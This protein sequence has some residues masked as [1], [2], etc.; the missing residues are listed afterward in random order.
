M[1]S[2]IFLKWMLPLILVAGLVLCS[3]TQL[4]AAN[5]SP[6][7]PNAWNSLSPIQ[8]QALAP[9]AKDW[10]SLPADR[11]QKWLAIAAKY[12]HMSPEDQK[13]AQEK[14]D[15]YVK[16]T[17]EQRR[18]VRENY[19]R[20][21]KYEPEQ[22]KQKWDEYNQ[23]PEDERTQLANHPEKKK[24]ITNLPTPAESKEQKLQPLKT[25]KKPAGSPITAPTSASQPAA[26]SAPTLPANSSPA[27]A[28]N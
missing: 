26:R 14:M 5:A 1:R 21:N 28:P 11:K 3:I 16:L 23:L 9:L 15:A 19:L 25:P 17:P 7:A 22:R 27:T 8:K 20:S 10:D 6:P 13:R 12:E 4:H 24:L 18:A 2:N